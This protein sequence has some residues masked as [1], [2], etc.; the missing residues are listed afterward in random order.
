VSRERLYVNST[1]YTI[2]WFVI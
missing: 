2:W 1:V